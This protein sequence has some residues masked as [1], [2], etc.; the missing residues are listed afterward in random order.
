MRRSALLLLAVSFC[1][2][3]HAQDGS[4]HGQIIDKDGKPLAGITVSIDRIDI[5]RHFE[6][7][8]DSNGL[9][10]HVGLP[11]G[12]YEITITS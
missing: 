1:V 11:A 7:K 6:T 2:R 9:Y 3:A 12:R 8:S 4:L 5:K 10:N